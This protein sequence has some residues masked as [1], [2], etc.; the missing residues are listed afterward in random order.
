MNGNDQE[1]NNNNNNNNNNNKVKVLLS[2]T[3]PHRCH[4]TF[5]PRTINIDSGCYYNNYCL[6][7]SNI[8]LCQQRMYYHCHACLP[9]KYIAISPSNTNRISLP[10]SSKSAV[11]LVRFSA[12]RFHSPHRFIFYYSSNISYSSSTFHLQVIGRI[13]VGAF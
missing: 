1:K 9:T 13:R 8:I 2:Q 3:T 12:S 7:I 5:S 11:F 6:R 10:I 4:F